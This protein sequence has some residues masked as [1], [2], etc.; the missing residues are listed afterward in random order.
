VNPEQ[1]DQVRDALRRETEQLQPVGL[2]YEAVQRRGSR[3]RNRG[4]ALVAVATVTCLAGAG[5]A[6]SHRDGGKHVVVA[7][8]PTTPPPSLAFRV[9]AGE[10]G[11]ATHFTSSDGVTYALSTAPGTV[12]TPT[13]P[14]QALYSTKDGE[15]WT[16][17]DQGEPWISDLAENSGVLYA[18]GTAPGAPNIQDVHF[19]LSTSHDGGKQWAATDLP[20]DQSPPTATVPLT[21]SPSVH[22]ARNGS[23]TVA[24]LTEQF[25]PDLDALVAARAAGRQNVSAQ[26][27]ANGFDVVD[28]SECQAS[29]QT[30]AAG[31]AIAGA[32]GAATTT[33]PGD[34]AKPGRDTGCEHPPVISTI[35]WSDLGLHSGADLT[36]QQILVSTDGS[37]WEHATGPTTGFVS[38]LVATTDGFLL[39]SDSGSPFYG[40][41]PGTE[42]ALFRSTDART[43]TNVPMPDHPAAQ[44][45]AGDRVIDVDAAGV[46]H[47]STDGGTTWTA[48]SV[49]AQLPAG[50]AAVTGTL[51]DAGP[52]GF[53]VVADADPHTG[54]E[55][56]GHDYLLFS[57]DGST[58]STS[59]LDAAGAPA[60]A[61]PLQVMVGADH[62]AVD[63]EQAI[64][65][66]GGPS[67][68]TTVLAT[69]KR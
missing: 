38:N 12:G 50:A 65:T 44:A 30:Q 34:G 35:T 20:F 53:A 13:Q 16:V 45:I 47:T 39:L 23:T 33:A 36:R 6:L 10:V 8:Q 32:A 25:S 64:G 68:L 5:V 63:Y 29:R 49:A 19:R 28:L 31:A 57:T 54:D 55:V 17:A 58:W 61:Y 69:P 15:H 40:S 1:L 3:R 62:I 51:V 42:T 4:R 67:K 37:H 41:T 11:Y 52:L 43:W 48:T 22:L 46:V 14:G 21:S 24:L 2:G 9:V 59:D 7:A 56:R 18:I 60:A 66:P 26:P 27:T